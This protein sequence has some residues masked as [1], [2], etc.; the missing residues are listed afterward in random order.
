MLG[1]YLVSVNL[2]PIPR[3]SKF[4]ITGAKRAGN[5]ANDGARSPSTM[6]LASRVASAVRWS[7]SLTFLSQLLTWLVT[8]AVIRILS[9]EDYGLMAM[10]MVFVSFAMIA[11][12]FGLGSALVQRS[13]PTSREYEAVHGFVLVL[14]IGLYIVF[15]I[16]A[17][18]VA[19]IFNEETLVPMLRVIALL[20][21]ILGFEVTALAILERN[22]EFRRKGSIYLIANVTGALVTL[23]LAFMSFGVWSLVYGNLLSAIVKAVA[24][25]IASGKLVVPRWRLKLVRPYL[26]FGGL[27]AVERILWSV[28]RQ[29]DVFFIGKWLGKE[30]LGYYYVALTLSSFVYDKTGGLLYEI[31]LPT[32]SRAKRELGEVAHVFIRALRILSFAVFPLMFGLAAVS[33]DI[34]DLLIGDRWTAASPLVL[35]LSLSMPAR[36]IGNI[37]PPALQG[38]GQPGSSLINLSIAVATMVPILALAALYNTATVALAWLVAYPV[39]L[40]LMFVHSRVS[41][42]VLWRDTASAVLPPLIASSLMFVFVYILNDKLAMASWSLGYRLAASILAGMFFFAL[43]A[44]L[45]MRKQLSE[46]LAFARR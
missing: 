11:N 13:A 26:H 44:Q 17:P 38:I 46:L 3:Y 29:A 10:S 6:N 23:A 22:L 4:C 1:G 35:I 39:I 2:I 8:I 43:V 9:P 20:F 7:A 5:D 34:V 19:D 31:S 14:N 24:I 42:G 36:I 37:F 21:P 16:A 12:D 25:N 33:T 28:H 41:L 32:F 18:I 45:T 15:Y 30:E 40:L 27:V